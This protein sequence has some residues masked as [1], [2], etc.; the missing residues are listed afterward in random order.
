MH[1]HKLVLPGRNFEP[2]RLYELMAAELVTLAAAVPTVWLTLLDYMDG[3]G[4]R[5]GSLRAALVAGS[6]PPRA[7]VEALEGRHG[8]EVAQCWGMTEA[9]GATKATLPPGLADA[10]AAEK[11][12][13]KL[14]SG[15]IAFG[16]ELRIV[17]D[18]GE[19]LP[20]DGVAF[21]HLQ[22]RGHII[23]AGYLKQEKL[24]GGWLPTGDMARIHADGSL[25]IVDRSKDVIKSGGEWISS[26]AIEGSALDHP[27]IAQAAVI[28]IPHPRWQERPLLIAVRKQGGDVTREAVLE[29]LRARMASWWLPDDVVFVDALPMTATG[30]INKVSLRKQFAEERGKERR[31]AG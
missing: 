3:K 14:R 7:L 17:D 15:R 4:L 21:G 31:K 27:G 18:E 24:P 20:R 28:A 12:E 29:H 6:K 10:P 13:H 30:K 8:V 26:V 5:F 22:A 23:A 11:V 25:D 2:D 9:L 19:V 16:T 1:G